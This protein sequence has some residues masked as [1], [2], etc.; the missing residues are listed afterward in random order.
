MDNLEI[1]RMSALEVCDGIKAKKL[2]PVEV[3]DAVLQHIERI[4]PTVNAY[5]T[6]VAESAKAEAKQ[7]DLN[8]YQLNINLWCL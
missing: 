7:I 5:C 2:S 1:C 3:I 8:G 6:V 4:N